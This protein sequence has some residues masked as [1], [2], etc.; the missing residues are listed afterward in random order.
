MTPTTSTPPAPP[1]RRRFTAFEKALLGCGVTAAL[2]VG[3][4]VA[5]VIVLSGP[6]MH[7]P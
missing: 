4:F 5:L 1:P 6:C 2:A 3:G 7:F